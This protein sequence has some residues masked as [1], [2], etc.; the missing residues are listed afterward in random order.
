[1]KKFAKKL[2]SLVSKILTAIGVDG[3]AHFIIV[4]NLYM[5][6]KAYVPSIWAVIFC[7]IVIFGKEVYDDYVKDST[8]SFKD[9]WCG[10][11]GMGVGALVLWL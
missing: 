1:M 8:M 6:L 10:V 9:I 11:L 4:E 7:L 5:V 3:L 2:S